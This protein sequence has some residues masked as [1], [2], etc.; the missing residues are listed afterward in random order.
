MK[1]FY[2][3]LGKLK[4]PSE[5][6][7]LV[8]VLLFLSALILTGLSEFFSK[9]QT[10]F[11]EGEIVAGLRKNSLTIKKEF[12]QLINLLEKRKTYFE[13]NWPSEE[14]TE[15]FNFFR[16]AGLEPSTEG[17][18]WLD[19]SLFPL[20]WTGNTANLKDAISNW[21]Q[22]SEKIMTGS[23]VLQ[24]KAS[25][26][27]VLI[28]PKPGI[29]NGYLA[30]FEL[31]AFQPQFQSAYLKEFQRLK[32]VV[33]TGA[34][35][36]F[37][38][39][40]QDT[41]ALDRL[42]SRTQDEYLSQQREE[43]ESRA[44]YFP[45]RNEK[46][47]ILATVTL[48]SLQLQRQKTALGDILKLIA[49]IL[50]IL[51]LSLLVFSLFH[52]PSNL[53]QRKWQLWL[54]IF[55]CLALMRFLLII[56][57]RIHPINTW[58][59]FSPLS[60]AFV[61]LLGLTASPADLF[62]SCLL[63]FAFVYFSLR[64]ILGHSGWFEKKEQKAILFGQ[65]FY[66]ETFL[67]ALSS[68]L[69]ILMIFWLFKKIVENSSL[70]LLGFSFS[71]SSLLIYLSLFLALVSVIFPIILLFR[72]RLPLI[73]KSPLALLVFTLTGLV[74][75]S[76]LWL[77][78]HLTITEKIIQLVFWLLLT[79]IFVFSLKK[80]RLLTL[81][82]GLVSLFA[83]SIIK[84]FTEVKNQNLTEKVLVHLVSSQKTWAEMALRQSFLELQKRSKELFSYFRNPADNDLARSL[85]NKTL[86]ARFNWNSCLYLQ[87]TDLK[88][89]T[90][91]ALNMPVFP[92]QTNDLPLSFNPVYDEQYLD[93]LGQEK[94]FLVGYQDFRDSEG[95]GGR[96]AVW[97]SLDP[98]LLPFFYSA[99]PYFE[100]LRLNTLP[101]LQHFPV[102][103]AVFDRQGQAVFQQ[104]KPGFALDDKI[105]HR[106]SLSPSGLW[107]SFKINGSRYQGFFISLEDG[108]IYVFY[109]P[110]DSFRRL[111]TS[112]L[113]FFF[114]FVFFLGIG[115]LPLAV[116]KKE[117]RL[118]RRSF[119]LRVYLAFLAGGL[120]PLFFFI[121]FSQTMV[122]RIFSNR[123]VQE[124]TNRAYFAR[125][126]LHDFI[127]LQEQ[128]EKPSHELPEDLVFWIS[129]TLNN[130]V[131]LF[132]NGLILSSSRLEFFETG[133]LSELMDGETYFRL[134]YQN[135]PLVVSRK[136][137]GRYSYQ[138]LTIPYRY[139]QDFYFLNLPFPFEKQEVSEA[140]SELFEFFLFT[141][142]FFIL[143]IIFFVG[144]IKRMIV[145]PI[146]KLI[147]AT[148]E[149]S[150]GN[151]D[152]KVEHQA[153][154][155]LKSLVDGFNTMIENLKAHQ[156]EL[157]DLSQKVAWTEM[158]RKMAH[159]I[160]NP[161]T[162]IQLSAEHI[163][164][165]QADRH[166]DFDRILKESISYIISEVENLRRIAQEFMTIAREHGVVKEKFDLKNIIL[167]LLQP[168][169]NTLSDR[170][171]FSFKE[172]GQDFI[173]VG[174]PGK[175]KI[176]VRNILINAI[177]AIKGKGRVEIMLKEK[178]KEIELEIKD[179][180]CGLSEEVLS[181]IFEPYYS[182]KEKGTGLGLAI[183][184]RIVEEHEGSIRLE[185]QVGQ[186]TRVLI[187]LPRQS[188]S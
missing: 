25:Y 117:W 130:D 21:A 169:K 55:I 69:A 75:F 7:S 152:I 95:H 154:D 88:L 168:F 188:Q 74:C 97:V 83:F 58:E 182:T 39:F 82:F 9:T 140:G 48:N 166:P 132:K 78:S 11:S 56:L 122:E 127:S 27:L 53:S 148:Q 73:I 71:F 170:I 112:F 86:L 123:F 162:P 61:S 102:F 89:L 120:I 45:L 96:L 178:E 129:S 150:L 76:L 107:T 175:I 4:L 185:S 177:E 146:N 31:L 52:Q 151:L 103:L 173:L 115:H 158:A 3:A 40:A 30:L 6:L 133:I 134:R 26:Y 118:F 38:S 19:Q 77:F 101:S 109:Q 49:I 54:F 183:C 141:S 68:W 149:V 165:V 46:G 153:E 186:G 90:S 72:Q 8:I 171:K 57:A 131:N 44:L 125:S 17:V 139:G 32:S 128:A 62:L 64:L 180:G 99:N 98:E 47:Q 157:A 142:I 174:D 119:S 135:Q 12:T 41:E 13:K 29:N 14:A 143:L 66:F 43:R 179:N 167:E 37:W 84:D 81:V 10:A 35:I 16:Q 105:K 144:T 187:T 111:I 161:L 18:A 116:K 108:N 93:I 110:A 156:K 138:T 176:A 63:L 160:K 91:F 28:L 60:L 172:D 42:F 145:V 15:V 124:A 163:L 155:E 104:K 20:V 106:I 147:R 94:H 80:A 126:I 121:F 34:D 159:E 33:R 2:R 65:K 113:K 100:L 23:F 67:I 79:A 85:W 1:S 36:N 5:R 181:H 22:D 184:K 136:S 164:K 59:I 114:L 51:A 137:L 87:A 50:A 70:N 92:E 24:D